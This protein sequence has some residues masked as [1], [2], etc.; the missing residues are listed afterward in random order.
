MSNPFE[1]FQNDIIR[2]VSK[3]NNTTSRNVKANVIKD[4]INVY[5]L[6]IDIVEGDTIERDLPN[7]RI[8]KYQVV[9]SDF[10][11]KLLVIPA[12]YTLTVRKI[13]S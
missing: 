8:E 9:R 12:H 4:S 2:I 3:A 6:E 7:G 1:Q 10:K 11:Q 5:D 13:L